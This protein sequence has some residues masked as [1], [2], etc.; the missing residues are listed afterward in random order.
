MKKINLIEFRLDYAFLIL[1]LLI[2][3][4]GI[5]FIL[6]IQKCWLLLYSIPP[7]N[8]IHT[9]A[10]LFLII[11]S[12]RLFTHWIV[13][14]SGNECDEWMV[15]FNGMALNQLTLKARTNATKTNRVRSSFGSSFFFIIQYCAIIFK[16]DNQWIERWSIIRNE[17]ANKA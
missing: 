14:F 1:Y 6:V 15:H 10:C 2:P 9:R 12:F 16:N 13:R 7:F 3:F 4:K 8:N 17:F 5:Y 11:F